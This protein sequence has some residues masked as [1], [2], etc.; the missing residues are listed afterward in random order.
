MRARRFILILL[1]LVTAVLLI[2]LLIRRTTRADEG[3]RVTLCPGPDWYGYTCAGGTGYAYIDA[4]QDTQLYADDDIVTLE[5]PFPFTFYGAEYRELTASSNGT[6]QFNGGNP[7]FFNEC[8]V[9]QPAVGMGNM[10]APYWDDLDL[11]LY[12][13]LETETVGEEPHRIFV[14]E[15]DDVPRFGDNPD[16]RVTF[17]VQLFED[18]ADIVFLYEDAT[19]FEGHNGSSATIG[20]QSEAQGLALQYSCNQAAVADAGRIYFAH[21]AEPNPDAGLEDKQETAVSNPIQ[22]KG[23]A[24]DLLTALNQN[25]PAILSH[26]QTQWRAQ[27]PTRAAD[28]AWADVTGNGRDE[29]I[30]LWYGGA[31]RPDIAQL[32]VLAA[33]ETGQMSLVLDNWLSTRHDPV[34]ELAIVETADLTHDGRPDWL[35]Q[36]DNGQLWAVTAVND[37]PP[38]LHPIP[39]R[40]HNGLTLLD[41]NN[42]G[43]LDIIRDGCQIT[44]RILT[45]WNGRE[46][47]ATTP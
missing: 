47:I 26:L 34:G 31:A 15:W 24:A 22:A 21:P 27:A 42:D 46:F 36:G 5:L 30:L 20:L 38:T 6:L 7:F 16:D 1:L 2:F 41:A 19:T 3:P 28:W 43:Q 14:I 44:G 23:T 32:V 4:S 35:V 33:D 37:A 11:R 10:I 29:L 13:H 9:E 45:Q 40:C 18:S 25:G 8:L 17:A 39:H 12:G